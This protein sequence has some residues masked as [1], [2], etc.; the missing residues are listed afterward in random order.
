[1]VISRRRRFDADLGEMVWPCCGRV[2]GDS[3]TVAG[4]VLGKLR[5]PQDQNAGGRCVRFGC[6]QARV[7][8]RVKAHVKAR[9]Q[10]CV[11]RTTGPGR[12]T[13]ARDMAAE[14]PA[15][16]ASARFFAKLGGCT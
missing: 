7:K 10:G 12:E 4:F 8:A 15:H 16:I 2:V 9:V 11:R 5:R 1:M 3:A 6:C 14:A 13:W